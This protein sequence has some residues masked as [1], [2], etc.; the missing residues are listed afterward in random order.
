MVSIHNTSERDEAAELPSS[1]ERAEA[2]LPIKTAPRDGTIIVVTGLNYGKGPERHRLFVRWE[3][4]SQRFVDQNAPDITLTHLD[5]W[6]PLP[7][8]PA[9]RPADE[10]TKAPSPSEAVLEQSQLNQESNQ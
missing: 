2:W 1:E 9:A 5:F 6:L 8:L 4:E 10:G 3:N 7:E